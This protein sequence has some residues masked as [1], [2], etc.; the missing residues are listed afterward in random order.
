MTFCTQK[1]Q[2][3]NDFDSRIFGV[4][5]HIINRSTANNFFVEHNSLVTTIVYKEIVRELPTP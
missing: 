3:L 1:K 5:I 4:L 2:V